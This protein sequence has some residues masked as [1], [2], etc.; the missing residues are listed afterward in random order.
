MNWQ[1][2][3][4]TDILQQGLQVSLPPA[5]DIRRHRIRPNLAV[6]QRLSTAWLQ[7]GT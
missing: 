1:P 5:C 3:G 7:K 6:A 2:S 4:L